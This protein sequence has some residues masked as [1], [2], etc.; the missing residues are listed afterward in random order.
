MQKV[1]FRVKTKMTYPH[2]VSAERFGILKQLM[3]RIDR[4]KIDDNLF[5]GYCKIHK[6]Y[7]VDHNHTK[8]EIRCPICDVEWLIKHN[9]LSSAEYENWLLWN[10]NIFGKKLSPPTAT[11]AKEE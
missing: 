3:A 7:F 9:R 8:E 10:S 1:K 11:M 6:K 5:L 4:A 2:L